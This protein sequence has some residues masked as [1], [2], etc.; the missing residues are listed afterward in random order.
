MNQRIKK[1]IIKFLQDKG[2]ITDYCYYV[3]EH[4]C[5]NGTTFYI[6]KGTGERMYSSSGRNQDWMD[7]ALQNN[8]IC[9]EVV[10]IE[11][12]LTEK[13]SFALEAKLLKEYGIESLTNRIYGVNV[14]IDLINEYKLNRI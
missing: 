14:D 11:D 12:Y 2:I 8:I 7:V 5:R 4:L 3:Y 6:G 13:Q 10:M 1:H 9:F